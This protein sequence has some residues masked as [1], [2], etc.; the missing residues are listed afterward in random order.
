MI[1]ARHMSMQ[2]LLPVTP[3]ASN[4]ILPW[5]I[6]SRACIQKYLIFG[7]SFFV[8]QGLRSLKT[9]FSKPFGEWQS[10]IDQIVARSR[11]F[12]LWQMLSASGKNWC[13]D[14]CRDVD[15]TDRHD[16]CRIGMHITL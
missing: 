7:L 8:K 9:G 6:F 12:F 2:T 16:Y 14:A 1:L 5:V 13:V 15:V 10:V 4:A 11:W 3:N